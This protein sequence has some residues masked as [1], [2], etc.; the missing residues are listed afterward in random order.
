MLRLR[1]QRPWYAFQQV[2]RYACRGEEKQNSTAGRLFWPIYKLA[3]RPG[4][5]CINFIYL[6][7]HRNC[8][9]SFIVDYQL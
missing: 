3:Q 9:I 7:K 2:F 4:I 5:S 1:S 8:Q 6:L